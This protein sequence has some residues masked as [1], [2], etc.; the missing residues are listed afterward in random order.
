M[1]STV[2]SVLFAIFNCYLASMVI[3]DFRV[4]CICT[5]FVFIIVEYTIIQT[6]F[7]FGDITIHTT[8][9]LI[10]SIAYTAIMIPTFGYISQKIQDETI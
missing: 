8:A 10:I 3:Y 6:N 4:K 7:I 5:C 1:L 9:S 2:F